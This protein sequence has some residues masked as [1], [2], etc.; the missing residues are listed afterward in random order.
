MNTGTSTS[1]GIGSTINEFTSNYK[2]ATKEFLESNSLVAKVAFLLLVLFVFTI[3]LRL[4]IWFLGY[5]LTDSRS[6]KLLDGMIDAKVMHIIPQ[7][8]KLANAVNV[9][10]STNERQGI[11]FTWSCWI[12]IKDIN[13]N[14]NSYKCVFYKGN[15]FVGTSDVGNTGLNFPNNAPGLYIAPNTNNLVVVMNTFNDINTKVTINDIPI[16][17][18]FNVIIRCQNTLLD[19][20]INGGIA[21]SLRLQGVPKQNYGDVYIAPNGGFDGYI[22][23]LWY[24]NSALTPTAIN[25]MI[26]N[27][28]NTNMIGTDGDAMNLKNPDYLS[29]R[30]Y[31]SGVGDGYNPSAPPAPV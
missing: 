9:S 5:Y 25:A 14:P 24:Y 16:R 10:R 26:S 19:V 13:T 12:Y 21:K 1:S 3:L 15:D 7:D 20:Y 18:W 4:G 31:F 17:K 30:W 27:G 23:N 29:L 22:S 8:P 6:P 11:E 28:P 2:N